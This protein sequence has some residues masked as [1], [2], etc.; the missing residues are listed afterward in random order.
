MLDADVKVQDGRAVDDA[1]VFQAV[2]HRSQDVTRHARL[3]DVRFSVGEARR[4]R[5]RGQLR[6]VRRELRRGAAVENGAELVGVTLTVPLIHETVV[7]VESADADVIAEQAIGRRAAGF[8]VQTMIVGR[9]AERRVRD[10][11]ARIRAALDDLI[12]EARQPLSL[13][14]GRRRAGVDLQ[15]QL[16]ERRDGARRVAVDAAVHGNAVQLVADLARI[17][18]ADVNGQV[19]AGL[20]GRNVGARYGGNRRIRAVERAAAT[21]DAGARLLGGVDRIDVGGRAGAHQ[22]RRGS[23]GRGRDR[24][25]LLA[26]RHGEHLRHVG[27]DDGAGVRCFVVAG[28]LRGHGVVVGRQRCEREVAAR[29]GNGGRSLRRARHGDR[30]A[31]DGSAADLGNDAAQRPGGARKGRAGADRPG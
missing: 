24:L 15:F 29:I 9:A 19:V 18:A 7:L 4:R 6:S 2:R 5:G 21:Q 1:G 20:V 30:N 25:E 8:D 23:R 28:F 12:D 22:R 13:A 11:V 16:P 26:H 17:A 31:R 14:V 27:K 10:P 3:S